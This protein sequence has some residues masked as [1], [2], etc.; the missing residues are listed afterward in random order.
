MYFPTS[1]WL[2]KLAIHTVGYSLTIKRIQLRNAYNL[3]ESAKD[4]AEWKTARLKRLHTML[5]H[6]KNI[7]ENNHRNGEQISCC[8]G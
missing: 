2:N 5:F 1:N 6:L 7:L 8:Q 3:D 4:H